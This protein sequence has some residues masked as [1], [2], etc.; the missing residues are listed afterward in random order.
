MNYFIKS[1]H[2]LTN[3]ELYQLLKAR[4]DIFVV[5]QA[6]PYPD[7]DDFDQEAMHYFLKDK[8]KLGALVRLLP[9]G[10]RYHE[11]SIGRVLVAESYRGYGYA[12]DIMT[13]AID[14]IQNEWGERRIKLQAQLYL[15]KFYASLGFKRIT[16]EYV[17][18]NIPHVDMI[19]E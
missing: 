17:E 4:V 6:C 3:D 13:R 8:D 11:A 9:S 16:N 14:Y 2:E 15:E 7:L 12:R 19:W 10:S 5:E 18:D 1:F